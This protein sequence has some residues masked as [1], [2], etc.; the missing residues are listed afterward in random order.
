[1]VFGSIPPMELIENVFILAGGSGTRLWPASN[2]KNPKQFLEVKEGKSLILL[3]LER[4]LALSPSVKVFIITLKDQ[5]EGII[6]ECG[7]VTKGRERIHILPEP[8]AKNTAPAIAACAGYLIEQGSGAENVLV[9]PA[10]HLIEPFDRFR[11]DVEKACALAGEGYLVTFGIKPSFPATGYGYVEMGDT[12]LEGFKVRSF[13]EK[14]DEATA[15]EFISRGNLWNSGMFVFT[16]NRFWEE[17]EAGSPV[18]ARTFKGIGKNQ[19]IRRQDD[20]KVIMDNQVTAGVYGK[21][22]RDSIDYAVMEKCGRSALVRASFNWN[23]IGSWDEMATLGGRKDE[24]NCFT[25]NSSGNYILSDIPVALCG[26]DDLVVVQKN[27]ALLICRKGSGQLV[28]EAVER[29]K[30]QDRTDLL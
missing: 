23:D 24:E 19:T 7:K 26:V 2:R 16:L 11:S 22:P 3:T 17:L 21:S 12:V 18:I 28:K 25:V 6:A 10:D 30:A 8:E 15:E 14:P 27:G 13:K 4:A 29:I 5:M 20:I 1:M 9:M